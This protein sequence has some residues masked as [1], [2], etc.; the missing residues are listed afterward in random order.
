MIAGAQAGKGTKVNAILCRHDRADEWVSGA[1][2]RLLL[3]L[4]LIMRGGGQLSRDAALMPAR[5]TA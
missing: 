2:M 4:I 3:A 1:D 5:G